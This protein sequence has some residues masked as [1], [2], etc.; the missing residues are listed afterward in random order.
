[1]GWGGTKNGPLL[2]LAEPVFDVFLTADKNLC[3]Q[4]NLTGRKLAIIVFPSNKLSIVKTLEVKLRTK[5]AQV[6]IGDYIEL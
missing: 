4:Q 5:I 1:M 2:T 6:T 3:Y